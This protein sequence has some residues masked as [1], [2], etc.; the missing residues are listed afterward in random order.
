MLFWKCL[1]EK[2]TQSQIA[3][4]RQDITKID[5]HRNSKNGFG[6]ASF[7]YLNMHPCSKDEAPTTK[8]EE[9]SIYLARNTAHKVNLDL[10][11]NDPHLCAVLLGMTHVDGMVSWDS[12]KYARNPRP[13]PK[14]MTAQSL[15]KVHFDV[16]GG[17]D[18]ISE[19]E[20]CQVLV[21]REEKIKL[22]YV[23]FTHD[24]TLQKLIE[25]YLGNP[26]FFSRRGFI[27]ISDEHLIKIF[28]K[29]WIAPPTN[30]MVMWR[31]TVVH[32]EA[33]ATDPQPQ[34]NGLCKFASFKNL[35]NQTRW[36]FVV[37][38]HLPQNLSRDSLVGIGQAFRAR[39]YPWILR[40][41]QQGNQGLPKYQERKINTVE[42]ASGTFGCGKTAFHYRLGF[43]R[44]GP[45]L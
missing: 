41:S 16:Y 1:G 42:K 7:A 13:K 37:G 24:P 17:K 9:E 20:R 44:C 27:G 26:G 12:V 22:G 28:E 34:L 15:T 11:E 36:R 14:T 5:Q 33:E 35:G 4:I 38:T 2:L 19:G 32:F 40:K 3:E 25:D 8:I 30:S 21:V 23:P 45:N 18:A 6:N 39:N 29:F 10:L 31:P 43:K